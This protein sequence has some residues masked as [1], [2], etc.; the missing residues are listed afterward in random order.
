MDILGTSTVPTS[1]LFHLYMT[2]D[3]LDNAIPRIQKAL[4][5]GLSTLI[6][7]FVTTLKAEG[8]TDIRFDHDN[9]RLDEILDD[10]MNN[11]KTLFIY[12]SRGGEAPEIIVKTGDKPPLK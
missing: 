5:H 12:L 1:E 7:S 10:I 3:R 9:A 6:L 11:D 2:K 4:E 8:V